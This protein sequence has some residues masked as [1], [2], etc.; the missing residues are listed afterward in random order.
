MR[1]NSLHILFTTQFVKSPS[2]LF[3]VEMLQNLSKFDEVTIDFYNNE[4]Q[5]YDVILFMGYDPDIQNARSMNKHA[6]IGVIDPRPTF[7]QQPEGADFIL[8]NGI[9]MKDLY[10]KFTP[11]IFIYYI[12]PPLKEKIREH[13]QSNKI[14]IGYHGN[15]VHLN[16]MYPRITR[17]LEML[18]GE[19]E[20]ELIVQYNFAALGKWTRNIPDSRK[21][22]IEHV[23]WSEENYDKYLAHADIGIVPNILPIKDPIKL[24]KK[25]QIDP[26]V[27]NENETDYLI[28]FKTTC[29]IGR[30]FVFAQYGIPVVADM[31][32]SALQFINDGIDG[33]ICY[34]TEAWYWALKRLA[35]S[36]SLRTVFASRM[37][38][39]FNMLASPEVLN[40][41]LL[42]FLKSLF[43]GNS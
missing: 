6:K 10:M 2:T 39:K 18:S 40:R 8:A 35:D 13:K 36:A 16:V 43:S 25:A 29:N 31:T 20:V 37:K 4:Y 21:V 23:P 1:N 9:E 30:L 7:K 27:F 34:S 11:N 22:K 5:K 24:K 12:Y 14:V 32:P 15:K 28:R 19:Y 33:F 17:A 3:N 41:D 38:D 26:S 42:I